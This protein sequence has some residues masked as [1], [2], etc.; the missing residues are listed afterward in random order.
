MTDR[1]QTGR[2]QADRVKTAD[3]QTLYRDRHKDRGSACQGS[4]AEQAHV[5]ATSSGPMQRASCASFGARHC[6]FTSGALTWCLRC[7]CYGEKRM[8]HL[9][10]PC[11]WGFFNDIAGA[12]ER[13]DTKLLLQ[14]LRTARLH[15]TYINFFVSYF[16]TRRAIVACNNAKSAHLLLI[17]KYFRGQYSV[18]RCGI[19]LKCRRS[20][21]FA[22]RRRKHFC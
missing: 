19:L 18:H 11:C 16:H 9:Q 15:E 5:V 7:G 22:R 17:I 8:Q 2:V 12:F 14:K 20:S 21:V 4:I 3:G 10:R 13:V 6:I 1:V